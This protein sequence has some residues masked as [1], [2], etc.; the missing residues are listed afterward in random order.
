MADLQLRFNMDMLVLSTPIEGQMARL[1]IDTAR[2]NELT[3]LLEPEVLED[4]YMLDAASGVQCVVSDTAFITPARLAHSRMEARANELADAAISVARQRNPQH[5]LVEIGP[6]GLPLD[7]SSKGSL[8]E[9]RDQYTRAASCFGSLEPLFD[10]FFLNGFTSCTDLKCALMGLRKITDKPIIASVN[11]DDEG[12]LA[13]VRR[14]AAGQ[15]NGAAESIEDAVRVMAE[16]G[17]QV[18]G[19]SASCDPDG[20]ARILRRMRA[21]APTMPQLA[22]LE[23]RKVDVEQESATDDNPYFSPDTM[24][25]AAETLR[26]AG[27]QFL[28]AVGNVTSPYTATLVGATVGDNVVLPDIPSSEAAF[29]SEEDLDALAKALRDRVNNALGR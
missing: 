20:V 29:S 12:L 11:V 25:D 6:C 16:F 26:N 23:V 4:V 10:A 15:Q 13:V 27:V 5:I 1:G 28:R 8:L 9:N 2:D 22:Q 21:V 3:L 7:P 17:A 14:R 18:A 19:V 24:V